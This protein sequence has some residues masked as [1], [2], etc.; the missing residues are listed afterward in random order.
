MGVPRCV[1]SVYG[2]WRREVGR[3]TRARIGLEWGSQSGRGARQMGLPTPRLAQYPRSE[4]VNYM[5][6]LTTRRTLSVLSPGLLS[7]AGGQYF[8]L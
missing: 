6:E 7:A 1:V 2:C 4:A 8:R 3:T 5:S